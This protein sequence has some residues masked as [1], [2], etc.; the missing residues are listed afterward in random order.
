MT[1]R[2][3]RRKHDAYVDDTLSGVELDG[4]SN[5]LRFCASCAQLDTR[6]RRALLLAHNLPEIH[7]SPAFIERLNAR[8][9]VER[10][11]AHAAR[12][13]GRPYGDDAPPRV[14]SAGSYATIAALLML[15]AGLAGA[16]N[17]LSERNSVV[18]L[19]PV[20]AFRSESE[21]VPLTNSTMV[22]A[23]PAG[24][25]LWPAVFVAQQAPWHFASIALEH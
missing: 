13:A 24:M 23:M 5:H 22:A 3:F 20:V 1:C 14:L 15:G 9:V 16:A 21:P 11:L 2:Q 12:R 4:M 8:L 25:P 18:R 17:L 10:D 6:V 7:P 19:S